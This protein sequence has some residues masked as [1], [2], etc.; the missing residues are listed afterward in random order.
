MKEILKELGLTE[1]EINV[2]LKLLKLGEASTQQIS[3]ETGINRISLYDMLNLLIKKRFVGCVVKNNIKTYFAISPK[4]ILEQLEEKRTKFK[5]ILPKLEELQKNNSKHSVVQ[6]FEGERAIDILN[7]NIFKDKNF[8][9]LS[10]GSYSLIKEIQKY[11]TINY[12]K[13]RIENNI[14][15]KVIS[16]NKLLDNPFIK[17]DEYKIIT[18][19]KVN[20]DLNNMKTWHYIYKNKYAILSIKENSF[21]V[22]IIEDKEIFE[23]QKKIFETMWKNI[24]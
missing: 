9:L 22:I 12:M 15:A 13:K 20:S 7:E 4:N 19:I 23:S 18:E 8:E 5:S 10:Y 11:T 21:S 24:K 3:K 2:Y 16:D 17:K 14:N 1:K 6:I